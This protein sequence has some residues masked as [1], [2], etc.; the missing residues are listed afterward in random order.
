MRADRG[1]FQILALFQGFSLPH[2]ACAQWGKNCLPLRGFP[3]PEKNS[4]NFIFFGK[5]V[6]PCL[7]SRLPLGGRL[8]AKQGGEGRILF[9][10][11]IF[12][13]KFSSRGVTNLF[14]VI[15]QCNRWI[16]CLL[17]F[18]FGQA[19]P[20]SL[21]RPQYSCFPLRESL[22]NCRLKAIP[23][24]RVARVCEPREDEKKRK[25]TNLKFSSIRAI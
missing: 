18:P 22:P 23:V 19:S 21:C 15:S 17:A 6:K 14:S 25:N 20:V 12:Y 7:T 13:R 8:L 4:A 11:D 1:L 16:R 3:L 9:M 5:N 2:R 24:S 10:I